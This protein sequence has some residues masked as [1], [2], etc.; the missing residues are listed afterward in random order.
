MIKHLAPTPL[1]YFQL[2]AVD[3]VFNVMLLGPNRACIK[4]QINWKDGTTKQEQPLLTP[5]TS[6]THLEIQDQ[7]IQGA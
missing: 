7:M 3:E 5:L 6:D 4:Q 2:P 1:F